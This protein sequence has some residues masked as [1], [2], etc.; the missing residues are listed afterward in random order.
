MNTD[1]RSALV[2]HFDPL[3]PQAGLIAFAVMAAA[4]FLGALLLGKR[5]GLVARGLCAAAFLCVLANPS[6]LEEERRGARDVAAIVLDSSPSNLSAQRSSQAQ[7]ALAYLKEK[8]GNRA[9]LELRTVEIPA[10]GTEDA[11]TRTR[12]FGPL[13]QA[14]S[15]VPRSRRAGVILVT[16][17]QIHDVPGVKD[18]KFDD[19]GPVQALLTGNR[20]EKDRKISIIE[21]PAYGLI[22]QTVRVRF[23][24]EDRGTGLPATAEITLRS[25]EDEPQTLRVPVGEEQ[26]FVFP[27]EHAGQNVL[28]IE[29]P[30]M[31]GEIS[32]ANNRAAIMVNGVRDR[33]RVLLI[34]GV[35][36]A[37]ERMWRDTLTSDPGVDLVHFTI[38]REPDKIDATP[39]QEMSLIAFP[40]HE[41]FEEKLK[42]FDLVIFDRYRRN[43]TMPDFYFGN[44]A[45]YVEHGGALLLSVGPEFADA[46]HSIYRS[47]LS[48][49]LPAAPDGQVYEAP[50]RPDLT[51]AGKRH[52]VTAGLNWNGG[53]AWGQWQRQIGLEDIAPQ[54]SATDSGTEILM[55]GNEKRPLLLLARKGRGRVAEIA[56]D[57]I[58]LWA[59]GYD[60]GGPHADLI[61]R[62]AHWL[63][64]EPEL[65]ENAL[66]LSADGNILTIRKRAI[67]ADPAEKT[68]LTDPDGKQTELLLKPGAEGWD[69]AHVTATRTGVWRAVSGNLSRVAI[70]GAPNAPENLDIRATPEK[71]APVLKASGGGAIWLSDTP[72]PEIR[73][74]AP[75]ALASGRGWIGLRHNGDYTVV[76]LKIRPLITP[77]IA[78]GGL[79]AFA[80]LAWLI[81]AGR[82]LKKA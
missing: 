67:K 28:E 61:R 74:V 65:E 52:P 43:N 2:L 53:T 36:H 11:L 49:V 75:D 3:I 46:S 82:R 63:M 8:L 13:A 68:I 12:V 14:L 47:D 5:R 32:A 27:I 29:T 38:L 37:G 40:F 51:D 66:D 79:L 15:D 64:K 19:F 9:D 72:R 20:N 6:L 48:D 59:R 33:L 78:A 41:L 56:S 73:R 39:P 81:E 1:L 24:V 77:W 57:Q 54:S 35:P 71:L 62:V 80:L 22:G 18:N 76:G 21:A 55:Q 60:G 26:S 69:E 31:D 4:I 16:D 44:I 34:S 23:R 70:V 25:G 30:A 10:A 50:F 42:D 7:D 17:G 45:R 58:W